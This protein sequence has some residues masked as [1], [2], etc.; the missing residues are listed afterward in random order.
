MA[1][2]AGSSRSAGSA[3]SSA[4]DVEAVYNAL[5]SFSTSINSILEGLQ[6][7]PGRGTRGSGAWLW[8]SAFDMVAGSLAFVLSCAHR[9]RGWADQDGFSDLTRAM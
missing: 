8:I 2:M 3:E 5:G 7:R 1:E 9:R 4:A 6:V